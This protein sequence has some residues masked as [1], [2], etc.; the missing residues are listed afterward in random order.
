MNKECLL[1]YWS[2]QRQFFFFSGI[3]TRLETEV[4]KSHSTDEKHD[5]REIYHL[6]EAFGAIFIGKFILLLGYIHFSCI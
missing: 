4:Y 5:S 6:V 3:K 1:V 2:C